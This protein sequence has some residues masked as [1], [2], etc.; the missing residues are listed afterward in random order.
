MKADQIRQALQPMANFAPAVLAAAEIVA[1]AEAA[2]KRIAELTAHEAT[3]KKELEQQIKGLE[4][5]K[6]GLN[7]D[8]AATKRELNSFKE[9]S[10]K[11][12]E[13]LSAK[14][15]SFR[16]KHEAEIASLEKAKLA[17]RQE[18]EDKLKE[19]DAKHSEFDSLKASFEKFKQSHGL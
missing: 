8:I 11:T 18:I 2:E 12:R 16:E 17:K 14:L 3:V 13:E 9:E 7:S 10:A 6:A 4:E 19:L 1:S 15:K 5:Y